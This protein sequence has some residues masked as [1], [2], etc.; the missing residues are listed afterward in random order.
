MNSFASLPNIAFS[1]RMFLLPYTNKIPRSLFTHTILYHP[2]CSNLHCTSHELQDML[3]TYLIWSFL[4]T[5]T[6]SIIFTTASTAPSHVPGLRGTNVRTMQFISKSTQA[7]NKCCHS[8]ALQ[9]SC[10]HLQDL[11][12]VMPARKMKGSM[13][14]VYLYF[15]RYSF[16]HSNIEWLCASIFFWVFEIYQKGKKRF[17]EEFTF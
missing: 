8:G 7:V 15:H 10:K 11:L 3:F 16:K 12:S 2:P 6:N 17:F 1:E 14:L 4:R 13:E 5:E 9:T